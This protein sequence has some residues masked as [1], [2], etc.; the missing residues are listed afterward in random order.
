M[1][2][3]KTVVTVR[4]SIENK[5]ILAQKAAELGITI[6]E[7]VDL[8]LSQNVRDIKVNNEQRISS[9]YIP[10]KESDN[11]DDEIDTKAF[12]RGIYARMTLLKVREACNMHGDGSQ[13]QTSIETVVKEY[14]AKVE[15]LEE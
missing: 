14:K 12:I 10:V 2:Q 3:M 15:S 8:I 9:E 13:L 1:T 6:S 4:T 11:T 7:Y 5:A